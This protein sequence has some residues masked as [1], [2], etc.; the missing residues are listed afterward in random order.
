MS[1]RNKT[2]RIVLGMGAI[3]LL[4]WLFLSGPVL[5]KVAPTFLL[6]N[7]HVT[8]FNPLRSRSPERAARRILEGVHSPSCSSF[9]QSQ[10]FPSADIEE[11]CKRQVRD[12]LTDSCE[13]FDSTLHLDVVW[14]AYHCRYKRGGDSTA[15]VSLTFTRNGLVL[16]SYERIY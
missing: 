13:M 14:L 12:P 3:I 6:R 2:G 7:A 10:A 15:D 11:I 1:M 9:L 16:K 8:I 5:V 4:L